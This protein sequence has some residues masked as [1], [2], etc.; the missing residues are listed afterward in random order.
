M[1]PNELLKFKEYN[2]K[3][4]DRYD[5]STGTWTKVNEDD[6]RLDLRGYSSEQ[7]KIHEYKD[8]DCVIAYTKNC[9]GL[10]MVIKTKKDM[11][12]FIVTEFDFR[13]YTLFR[14]DLDK[15]YKYL[16]FNGESH[17][18]NIVDEE[19]YKRFQAKL[20]LMELDKK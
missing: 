5:Y 15:A 2:R 18:L 16:N 7:K 6:F 1:K 10:V 11:F 4:H 12:A 8:E 13:G 20:S 3:G 17:K 19:L 14:I 9:L